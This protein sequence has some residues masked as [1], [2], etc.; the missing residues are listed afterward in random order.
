MTKKEKKSSNRF[1]SL[2]N[3]ESLAQDSK[4]QTKNKNNNTKQHRKQE[5]QPEKQ[6]QQAS[7]E[8]SALPATSSSLLDNLEWIMPLIKGKTNNEITAQWN[9]ILSQA[10]AVDPDDRDR[11]NG[12][13][14]L[15][16]LSSN[17]LSDFFTHYGESLNKALNKSPVN[18]MSNGTTPVKKDSLLQKLKGIWTEGSH[19]PLWILLN[20]I[21]SLSAIIM[22]IAET[23]GGFIPGFHAQYHQQYPTLKLTPDE[24]E[25]LNQWI[26]FHKAEP[27]GQQQQQQQHQNLP[28]FQP[29][30]ASTQARHKNTGRGQ[31]IDARS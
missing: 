26:N 6:Q 3:N 14:A 21:A 12:I 23:I 22:S 25:K 2:P 18:T 15:K 13:D 9:N 11:S 1:A 8:T 20:L 31:S 27:A 29:D 7:T 16:K 5:K 19:N 30:N 4:S 24:K 10:A 17:A 28:H